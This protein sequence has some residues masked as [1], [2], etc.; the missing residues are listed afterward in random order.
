L[1]C[2]GV[3]VIV[4]LATRYVSLA[5]LSAALAFP[6]VVVLIARQEHLVLLGFSLVICLLVFWTHRTNISRLLKGQET[7]MGLT[8]GTSP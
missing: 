8:G 5:S 2:L 7:K 3:F 6:I 1:I 4:Y